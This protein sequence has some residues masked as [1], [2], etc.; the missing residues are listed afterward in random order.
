MHWQASD[1]GDQPG[2]S[3]ASG[4]EPETRRAQPYPNPCV[5]SPTP[6][7]GWHPDPVDPG[8][9]LRWWDGDAWTARVVT[10]EAGSEAISW[11]HRIDE[12]GAPAPVAAPPVAPADA[13][14]GEDALVAVGTAPPASLEAA[15]I[16]M[17]R[18]RTRRRMWQLAAAAAL[19]LVAAAGASAAMLGGTERPTVA[20][21]IVYHDQAAGFSLRYPDA[22]RIQEQTPGDGLRFQI[23]AKGAA[24]TDANTVSVVVG[25]TQAPLPALHTLADEVTGRLLER[26]PEIRLE[27]AVQTRL[28]HS[29][30]YALRLSDGT[31]S[32]PT[33][34]AQVV[35][36]T[37][38][39]RPLTVTVTIR[40]PRTAPNAHELQKFLDSITSS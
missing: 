12:H 18:S 36:R 21:T 4:W 38:A 40:E 28:A 3:P 8:R 27:A 6:G 32:P 14:S 25:T 29:T 16:E 33:R 37:T 26:F 1:P 10:L 24:P 13:P 39:G 17:P 2:L 9:R 20:P 7:P 31:S 5:P 15:I 19:L 30:A 23:G 11:H 34:I 35:G 22:W